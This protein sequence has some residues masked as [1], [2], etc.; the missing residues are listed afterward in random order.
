MN[1]TWSTVL[2]QSGARI[3]NGVVTDFGQPQKELHAVLHRDIAADLSHLGLIAVE[4]E[5]ARD[6]LQNQLSND[7]Q[8]VS[9]QRS[10]L[11]SYN[12]AK[13]RMLTILR[14]FLSNGVYYMSMPAE[15]VEPTVK[16]L[17]MFVLRS[18]VKLTPVADT[19]IRIG[20]SGPNCHQILKQLNLEVSRDSNSV[21]VTQNLICLHIPGPQTRY[22]MIGS[23]E[24]IAPL[25]QQLHKQTQ[26][27]GSPAWRLLDIYAGI[28]CLHSGTVEQFVPQMVNLQLIDGVSFKK[29]CYPGQEIVARMHYLGQ[30]KK[31]MYR[32]HVDAND[33]PK[34]GDHLFESST[35]NTQSVGQVVEAQASPFGGFDV[36]AVIQIAAA[37]QYSLHLN[38]RSGPKIV[39]RDLPYAF[40]A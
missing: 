26:A 22:E 36:L 24:D 25:W 32:V 8:Q 13:G 14:L 39:L 27:V 3:E 28:P 19:R 9:E 37:E 12:T 40:P 31:R 29:G 7:V 6:F 38:D 34:A 21:S 35:D 17:R 11:S 2:Q 4:G 23:S 5:D 33:A 15:L 30:L 10:Q 20:V 16:R 1:E 18:K